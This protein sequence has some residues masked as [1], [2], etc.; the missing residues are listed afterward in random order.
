MA[1]CA[2]CKADT[3]LFEN[4]VPICLTCTSERVTTPKPPGTETQIHT[5]LK[6]ELA[7]ATEEA[8]CLRL[9]KE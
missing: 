8:V 7:V 2:R 1:E 6:D 4:G 3:Q 5:A 9:G